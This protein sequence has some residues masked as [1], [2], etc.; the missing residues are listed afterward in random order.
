MIDLVDIGVGNIGSVSRC[1]D[2]L[3]IAYQKVGPTHFP[4]GLNP[5]ILPG[6]GSFGGIMKAL[7][8]NNFDR[9][10]KQLLEEGTP[11]LGLC[12]GL[13]ILFEESEE[14]PGVKGLGLIPGRVVR[15]QAEK[16]PQIGWNA[17]EPQV[18]ALEKT[19]SATALTPRTLMP[20]P[21]GYVYFVNSYYAAPT[22]PEDILYSS[23]YEGTFCAAVQSGNLTAFQ[24]HPEKS[25]VFGH[26]L[27]QSWVFENFNHYTKR[28]QKVGGLS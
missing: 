19:N 22:R 5:I 18:T 21:E 11:Y 6:V 23:D 24:F 7:E 20:W 9:H 8:Q 4:D 28:R 25:G 15:Y 26:Y 10:L 14:S 13:Q 17:I 16:V 12:V 27:I 2:R 3:G 1:L